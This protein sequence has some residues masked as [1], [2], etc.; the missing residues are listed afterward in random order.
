MQDAT[1]WSWMALLLLGVFH[2]INPG[3]G[4]LFA[5]ALGL[6]EQSRAAVWRAM[7]PLAAGH[8][9][10]IGAA[11]LIVMLAGV[12]AS[13]NL[14]AMPVGLMLVAMGVFRLL[15]CRHPRW[16]SMRVGMKGLTVWSFLMA[17]AH[18]AGLM[19]LPVFLGMTVHAEDASC[20][21]SGT[22]TSDGLAALLATLVHSGGYLLT[23]ALA[24][25]LVYE[26]LGLRLLR[27]GWINLDL[28]WAAA[29]IVTGVV[30]LW[31]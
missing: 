26:K 4:W 23:T 11:I 27:T 5:V 13:T 2:G 8:G 10:A 20:H 28:I 17:S 19:V 9:L 21:A 18:G 25:W 31:R 14:V 22:I 7:L 24:A 15:R 30:T 6:Q 12:V 29:L 3:M 1:L 16:A